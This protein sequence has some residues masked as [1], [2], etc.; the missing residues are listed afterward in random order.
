M[1]F[2]GVDLS[3]RCRP[4]KEGATAICRCDERGEFDDPVLLTSDE[5]IISY[6][7]GAD[8]WVGIDAPL[9]VPNE[10]GIRSGEREI[11]KE[12]M[13]VLPTNKRFLRD[14]CGGARGEPL[15]HMLEEKAFRRGRP[16]PLPTRAY[17]ETYPFSLISSL[18][19]G[20]IRYKRGKA[21]EKRNACQ[22]ILGRLQGWDPG[23]QIPPA[24][25]D[26]VGHAAPSQMKAVG[27]KVDA[28]LCAACVYAHWLYGGQ[29][30]RLVGD[31]KD[32]YILI[33]RRD[34]PQGN[35]RSAAPRGVQKGGVDRRF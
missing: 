23:I 19:P 21:A 2:I 32:G 31:E 12:G 17:F 24:L 29:R 15:S 10:L 22:D 26:E 30:T 28:L 7:G 14:H 13:R 9:L 27:D 16:G 3:W 4:F 25:C 18:F 1:R 5:D 34:G 8:A 20:G 11:L 6:I 33:V 35:D